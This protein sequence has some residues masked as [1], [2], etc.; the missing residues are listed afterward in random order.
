VLDPLGW[1]L[2]GC[3]VPQHERYVTEGHTRT[4]VGSWMLARRRDRDVLE[5]GIGKAV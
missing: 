1:I 5:I 3:P 2:G 4:V